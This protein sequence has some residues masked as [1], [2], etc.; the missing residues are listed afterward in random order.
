MTRPADIRKKL[1][2]LSVPGVKMLICDILME[3]DKDVGTYDQ[4]AG[5]IAYAAYI[6]RACNRMKG[7]YDKQLQRHDVKVAT[8]DLENLIN[9]IKDGTEP[10][11][12]NNKQK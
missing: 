6:E 4:E 11:W 12:R 9:S 3:H 5:T 1:K 2:A 10:E 8:R 7:V